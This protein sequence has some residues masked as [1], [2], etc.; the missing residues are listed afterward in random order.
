M[1]GHCT[2]IQQKKSC[3]LRAEF[4]TSPPT[5]PYIS[6]SPSNQLNLR[7][8]IVTGRILYGVEVKICVPISFSKK[9][10]VSLIRRQYKIWCQ[11]IFLMSKIRIH[12]L[13]SH[14]FFFLISNQLKFERDETCS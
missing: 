12:F 6:R 4:L 2:K 5:K 11:T 14:T 10:S 13:F 1:Y 7:K 9:M 8:K 3:A